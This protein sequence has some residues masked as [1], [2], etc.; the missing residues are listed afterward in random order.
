MVQ[1]NIMM[2][3]LINTMGIGNSMKAIVLCGGEGSKFFPYQY[4]WQ[5]GC[6]PIGN[7]SN[8]KRIIK[9][10][11]KLQ[12]KD[13]VVVLDYHSQQ[14]R[15]ELMDE[16]VQYLQTDKHK[17]HMDLASLMDQSTLIYYG[18]TYASDDDL[19]RLYKYYQQ[20]GNAILY[21]RSDQD[22]RVNDYIGAV[23]E[24]EK[25]VN[26]YG[27]ARGHYVNS[28]LFGVMILDEKIK[29]YIQNSPFT[30]LNVPVGG[31]PK[32][33][34][35]LEQSLLNA[36]EDSIDIYA[37][38]AQNN[39]IDIDFPWDI[40]F[41]N[42]KFCL[43]NVAT[44]QHDMIDE[45]ASISKSACIRGK[46]VLGKNSVIGHNV[47]VYGNCIVGDN[48]VIENNVI[49]GKNCVIGNHCDIRDGCKISE[50]T[51][52]GHYNR[53]GFTA[54]VSG[55][56]F[57]RVSIVHHSEVYG[58]VGSCTDI[59]AGCQMAILRFDDLENP[60]KVQQK[61]YTN[62]FTNAIFLGDNTRTGVGNIFMPGVKIGAHCALGPG[63]II[64]RDIESH[65]IVM[66]KQEISISE[67]S[68]QR[69][70]W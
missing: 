67:W 68:S 69:Y 50:N 8:I 60:N 10:L 29:K 5:K 24:S 26:I 65:K 45:S 39:V 58:V 11:K 2:N 66:P 56:T 13:I 31:M 14:V 20:K 12:I 3:C 17:I 63:L 33:E 41:A 6:I 57:D 7:E 53:I 4:K 61:K 22:T 44:L 30:F 16:D 34:F 46:I 43:E 18:D 64:D 35:Y 9:Q 28:R 55:V 25:I 21:R 38:E 70:G 42:E 1:M 40:L 54:E 32:F 37:V 36:I 47:M 49:L 52:I 19:Y 59:A 48:T 23:V 62:K 51:V 27:H 15:Y